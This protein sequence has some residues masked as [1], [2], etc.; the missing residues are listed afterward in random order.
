MLLP[1]G[2]DNVY[3]ELD[4]ALKPEISNRNT[5]VHCAHYN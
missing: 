5:R 2:D 1:S 4:E 3:D